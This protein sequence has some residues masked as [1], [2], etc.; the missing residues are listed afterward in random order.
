MKTRAVTW[1]HRLGFSWEHNPFYLLSALFMLLGCYLLVDALGAPPERPDRLLIVLGVLNLYEFALIGWGAYLVRAR[2]AYRAAQA[3]GLLAVVF[4]VDST[5]VMTRCVGVCAMS[6]NLVNVLVVLLGGLKLG[7][8]LR[9]FR[10][11]VRW[12]QL[13]VLV[14]VLGMIH[15]MPGVLTWQLLHAPGD[16]GKIP[17]TALYTASWLV[18]ALLAFLPRTADARAICR[19]PCAAYG[20]S[21]ALRHALLLGPFVSLAVHLLVAYRQYDS[22]FLFCHV[23]PLLLGLAALLVRRRSATGMSPVRTRFTLALGCLAVFFSLRFP[24]G[25]IVAAPIMRGAMVSPLRIALFAAGLLWCLCLYIE[26]RRLFAALAA[27][28]WLAGLMGHTA[29]EI[30]QT[31][32]RIVARVLRQAPDTVL[33]WGVVLVAVSFVLLGAGMLVTIVGGRRRPEPSKLE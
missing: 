10:V 29:A 5:Y 11:R 7:L 15:V 25:L 26:R 30:R 14:G 2:G 24:A 6:G 17:L 8:L 18:G 12:P 16:D 9:L 31:A 19:A 27:A 3:L 4:L 33:E 21:R 23:S 22:P 20:V 13:A 28:M 32:V 1:Y